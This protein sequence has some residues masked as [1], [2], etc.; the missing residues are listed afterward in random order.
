MGGWLEREG[1]WQVGQQ[2][3]SLYP[4]STLLLLPWEGSLLADFQVATS[5]VAFAGRDLFLAWLVQPTATLAPSVLLA[6]IIHSSKVLK[7]C[8]QLF[9]FPHH[10]MPLLFALFCPESL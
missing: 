9:I 4:E 6:L 8:K 7:C 10:L 3:E 2:P 5:S 1:A